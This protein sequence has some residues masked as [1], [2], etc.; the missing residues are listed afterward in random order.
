M[1]KLF[2]LVLAGL[3]LTLGLAACGSKTC[4]EPDCDEEVYKK[5]FCAEHYAV[6]YPEEALKDALGE[7]GD[8]FG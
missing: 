8:L 4:K 5:G 6:N 1:K 7:L 3:M 2:V